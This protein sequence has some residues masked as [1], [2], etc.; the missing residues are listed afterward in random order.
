MQKFVEDNGK[1]INCGE[2]HELM[3]HTDVFDAQILVIL[4]HDS[5]IEH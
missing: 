3:M 1:H 5:K 2:Q 4:S